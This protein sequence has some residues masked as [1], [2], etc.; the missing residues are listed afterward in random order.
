MP[1]HL[2][3]IYQNMIVQT[4]LSELNEIVE[5]SIEGYTYLQSL[6]LNQRSQLMDTIADEIEAIGDELFEIAHQ[7]TA[8]PYPR[9]QGEKKRTVNQWRSYGTA[10]SDGIY[11]D[12]RIDIGNASGKA[13]IR[14]YNKGVGPVVVFG[15]S[16]FPYAFSTA[17]GDTASAIGAGCPVIVK[18]HPAHVKTSSLMAQAIT[19]GLEKF[20]APIGVFGY[21]KGSSPELGAALVQH[22]FIK[23]VAFTGSFAGGKALFDLAN[24]RDEPIPV[25]AEMGSINPVIVLPDYVSHHAST[26]AEQYVGSLT[27]GVGQF[28]TNPGVLIGIQG[29]E[30][31]TLEAA[32][33][34]EIEKTASAT[35]LH[36]G[37]WESYVKGTRAIE[38]Q[39]GVRLIGKGAEGKEGQGVPHVYKV[40]AAAYLSNHV[41]SE[42]VFG[43]TGIVVECENESQL[44]TIVKRLK[45]QLT[46][47]FAATESDY[48][49]YEP[50]FKTAEEKAGR[51]LFGGM[52]TGVEV[53]YAMHHG[54]PFP[55]TTD[56]RFTSV[57][58][59]SI[60]RFVRP[61]SFQSWPEQ[62]L[63][64]ELRSDNP[65]QILRIVDNELTRDPILE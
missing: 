58:P 41:L 14:K 21:V 61:V 62:F 25:F 52:P 59:D 13:D 49:Q 47:T 9:L 10:V 3:Q 16:N 34:Q 57:G 12:A 24:Q 5:K 60:K 40:S 20:G 43:P 23:A 50:L 15:A 6:S 53:V 36:T 8:L 18:E 33:L 56:A 19:V 44:Y 22:P 45:G 7:E 17:G 51:I 42:E 38:V 28:C 65:Y 4:S 31:D 35:M 54:G 64:R 1:S 30:F 37:I 46:I 11:V 63:P 27:L 32:L 39:E 48:V 55:A 2:D 29:I 26:F